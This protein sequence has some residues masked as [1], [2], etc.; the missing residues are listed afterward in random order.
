MSVFPFAYIRM[1][2]AFQD[3]FLVAKLGEL[4]TLNLSKYVT[5]LGKDV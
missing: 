5:S 3:T 1:L 4:K 2:T